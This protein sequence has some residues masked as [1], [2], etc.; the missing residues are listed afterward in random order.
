MAGKY[1]IHKW[2]YKSAYIRL[3]L[4]DTALCDE[5]TLTSYLDQYKTVYIKPEDGCQGIGVIKAW[6]E[7]GG[8]WYVIERGDPIYC[9]SI[10]EMYQKLFSDNGNPYIVQRAIQ[11]AQING[12]PIDI[13]LMMMRD[14]NKRWNYAGM[15]AKLAMEKSIVTNVSRGGSILSVDKALNKSLGISGEKLESIKEEMIRLCYV[16]NRVYSRYV[17]QSEIGYDIGVDQSGK[18]WFIEANRGPSR[19]A[20]AKLK[21]K[22][23]YRKIRQLQYEYRNRKS[24]KKSPDE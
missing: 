18:I 9:A 7:N 11:L 24:V 19:V 16:C 1:Q 22:T 12:R 10:S 15:L 6:K 17:Y 23:M 8:Y 5:L 21:D 20:F 14:A 3:Y 2:F 4:P 13:R